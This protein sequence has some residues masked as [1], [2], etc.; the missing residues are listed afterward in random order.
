MKPLTVEQHLNKV[1]YSNDHLYNPSVFATEFV[2]FIKLVNGAEGEEN[3]TPVAHYRMLDQLANQAGGSNNLQNNI[4]NLCSRGLA[5]TAIFGEYLFIWLAVYGEIPGYGK[6]KYALYVSDSIDNGVKNMRKRIEL[7]IRNSPF[8]QKYITSIKFTDTRWEF[9]NSS[10]V[11][12]VVT[13]HGAT[14]G[15]RGTVQLNSRPMLAVLDDLISDSDARSPT[16]IASVEDTVYKAVDY[17]LHPKYNKIIWSGTPFN[18]NDPLYKAIES[19]AWAVNVFPVCERFPCKPEEFASAWVDRFD[20][21]FVNS[22]YKKAKAVN[23]LD[24]FYQ[25]LMLRIM[26]EEER[27]IKDDEIA[28][29]D[30]NVLL[31]NRHNY[32]F[33]ITTDF[34]TT[35]HNE[36]DYSVISVWAI[37][38]KGA[39]YWVDGQCLKQEMGQNVDDLFK[40]CQLYQPQEVG[41]EVSGQQGGFV[42]WIDREMIA[43]GIYFNWATDNNSARPGIRPIASKMQRFLTILPKMKKRM[44][45][46]PKQ[47]ENEPVMLECMDE[48]RL[49]TR[50]GFKSRH[51]D[52]LDTISMLTVIDYWL[53]SEVVAPKSFNGNSGLW[54]DDDADDDE[55][56]NERYVV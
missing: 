10:G 51:D 17:A 38:S 23:K 11:Q 3:N 8:L 14:T 7:R 33:Y 41:I 4:A 32:N 25:E 48:L 43:K 27:L 37:N 26:S 47:W 46:F 49:A 1:D 50:K 36:G 18:A 44:V 29:Y 30:R 53:P 21:D 5:K 28:W 24:T 52:F 20:Y 40:F 6:I 39:W 31:E 54:E 22:K 13:G 56:S 15:V 42:S 45:N 19:G 35:E 16:V 12:F 55:Y 34:A 2:Q 9:T